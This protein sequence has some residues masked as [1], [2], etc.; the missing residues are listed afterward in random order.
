MEPGRLNKRLSFQSLSGAVNQLG[1]RTTWQTY[2]TC[3]GSVSVLRG[4]L[5]Y[6]TG[7]F[8]AK[9][10][11]DVRVRYTATQ[12]FSVGDRFQTEDG[13]TFVIDAVMNVQMR[14]REI[15]ILAHVIDQAVS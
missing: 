10:T 11:Y 15:Q 13:T 9:S 14:N 5:I 4:Q 3:Y 12:T 1:E 7:E 8:I 6:N 2:Y